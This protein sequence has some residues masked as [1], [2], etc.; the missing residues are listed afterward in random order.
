VFGDPQKALAWLHKPRK[1]FGDQSA[2]AIIQSEA[3]AQLV[4]D[5][6]IKSMLAT[7][8]ALAAYK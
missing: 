7:L 3:G 6:L 5:T 4:G 2:L 8:R 1:R